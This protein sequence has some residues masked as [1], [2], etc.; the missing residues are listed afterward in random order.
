MTTNAPTTTTT[1]TAADFF[2]WEASLGPHSN[3]TAKDRDESEARFKTLSPHDKYL[4]K[5]GGVDKFFV[6]EN[7]VP[8]RQHTVSSPSGKYR[9]VTTP[10]GTKPGSWGY[11]LGEVYREPVFPETAQ[12]PVK[13]AEVRRNYMSLWHA[14]VEAHPVTGHDY[15]LTGEDY[16]GFTVVNL[17]TGKV[18]THIPD[19]AFAGHGW[20][21]TSAELLPAQGAGVT[22]KVSGCYWACPYEVRLYDF[23]NPDA[24]DFPEKGL[25][26]L[27]ADLWFDDDED[28]TLTVGENGEVTLTQ[29]RKRF[30]A[31][32]EWEN[33][34]EAK[35]TL[36]HE[37]AHKAKKA[38]DEEGVA[39]AKQDE[40][41]L[42][43]LYYPK[44]DD[45]NEAAWE[46]VP[47]TRGVYARSVSEDG[48]PGKYQEVPEREWKSEYALACERRAE[49]YEQKQKEDFRHYADTEPLYQLAKSAWPK[50]CASRTGKSY[51]SLVNRWD[52]D[53]NP[54]RF[55]V[56]VGPKYDGAHQDRTATLVWGAKDGPVKAECWTHGKNTVTAVFPR[57]EEGWREALAHARA[58]LEQ[59]DAEAV[60]AKKQEKINASR[61]SKGSCRYP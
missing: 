4:V 44:G 15:L 34:V 2:A 40:Q 32:G 12:P 31:T 54:F 35:H 53:E 27:T 39:R 43:A 46:K 45:E 60:A 29:Y 55:Y 19:E 1:L 51:P 25:P 52:G 47:Y 22:L 3:W 13:V 28:T 37:R 48:G 10:Y 56:R 6:P 30:K 61:D 16:Q 26:H 9:L 57:T 7:A 50:D 14:W 58:H 38:G 23:T 59:E 5:R 33:E 49:E 36:L 17:T 8:D 20:C 24:L 18:S 21:P 42:G 41:E 11:T